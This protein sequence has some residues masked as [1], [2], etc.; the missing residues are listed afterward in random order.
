[1][2]PC[3]RLCALAVLGVVLCFS[4][5][6]RADDAQLAA[7]RRPPEA[8]ATRAV[9]QDERTL[10]LV[11]PAAWQAGAAPQPSAPTSVTPAA[12]TLP[13]TPCAPASCRPP[14][15]SGEQRLEVTFGSAQLFN[16]QSVLSA[17]R[18][19][20]QIV[21]VTS[22]LFMVEWLLHDRLSLLTLFNLPLTTQKT[23]VDGMI[24]EEF[25][26]P[27]VAL[28]LRVSALRFDVFAGSRLEVQLAALGGV[29]VGSTSGDQ[30]FPLAAGRFHFAS[31]GG[32]ALY[33][34]GAFAFQRDTVAI[35]YG[36]GHRF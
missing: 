20:E 32:F 8:L 22:A 2:R 12:Q 25:V 30:I 14:A 13:A 9:E 36:I 5:R 33:L 4:W 24:Q 11:V 16:H 29:T 6:A 1:M 34:G 28:G 26:A 7:Q 31:S 17:G 35:L 19:E 18:I 10:G 23:V 15:P 3:T 27:S 21:P